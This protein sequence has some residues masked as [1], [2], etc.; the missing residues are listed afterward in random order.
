MWQLVT[1]AIH[2][3]S[4]T[5][6]CPTVHLSFSE[7]TNQEKNRSLSVCP[8]VMF[9]TVTSNIDYLHIFKART[10]F[11]DPVRYLLVAQKVV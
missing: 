5:L 2:S 3:L 8:F 7:N 10:L 4:C 11:F 9:F 1:M 6:G